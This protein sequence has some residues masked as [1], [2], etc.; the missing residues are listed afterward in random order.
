VILSYSNNFVVVRVPKTGSTSL[1]LYF[2]KSGLIDKVKDIFVEEVENMAV[3]FEEYEQNYGFDYSK[4]PLTHKGN[5]HRTFN[6]LRD[7]GAVKSDMPCVATIRE[8]LARM[9]SW[10]NYSL[11]LNKNAKPTKHSDPNVFWSDAKHIL[12]PQVSFFP[13]HATLFNTENLHEHV[14][15][16]I[17]D[18]GGKVEKRI[19]ARKNVNNAVDEF[20]EKLTSSTK[21]DILDTYSKDFELWEKAYAVYN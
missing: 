16:Y 21:Q 10:F 9:S 8:P 12:P 7:K 1:I 13:E 11:V 2:L 19:E 6:D 5:L 20:L 4:Y 14:S 15:K 17:L 18:K 3:V